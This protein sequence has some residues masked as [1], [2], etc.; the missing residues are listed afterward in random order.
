MMMMVVMLTM[1]VITCLNYF[2]C[3][4]QWEGKGGHDE[5]D[6]DNGPEDHDANDDDGG[7]ANDED[8]HLPGQL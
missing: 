4:E 7:D 5:E 3:H 8:D 1:K 2:N 6:V